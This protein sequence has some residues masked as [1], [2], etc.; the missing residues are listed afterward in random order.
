MLGALLFLASFVAYSLAATLTYNWD[1]TWVSAAP[2]GFTRPVIGIN[3]IFPCPTIKANVGDQI[4]INVNNQLGNQTTSLH[5][6]GINQ[7]GSS[8]MDGPSGVTQCPIPPGS[9]FTYKY[10]VRNDS[11]YIRTLLADR[12]FPQVDTPG[13]YWYHS[14]NHGQYPDGLRGPLIVYDPNDPYAGQFGEDIVLTTSG[15]QYW[16]ELSRLVLTKALIPRL[17]P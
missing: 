13:T 5:W 14:H 6:H 16:Y 3:G 7:Y 4:V 12:T 9:S 2:D 8:E 17:V 15:K 11:R 10:T 1:I